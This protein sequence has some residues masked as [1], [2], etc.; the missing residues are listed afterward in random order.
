M[1]TLRSHV[2][3]TAWLI[4]YENTKDVDEKYG[5]ELIIPDNMIK[6]LLFIHYFFI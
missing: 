3:N 5:I 2:N 4:I 6:K 1:P